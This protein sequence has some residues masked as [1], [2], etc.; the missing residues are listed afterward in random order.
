MARKPVKA[1]SRNTT[2][3]AGTAIVS[4]IA[5]THPEKELWPATAANPA[6]TKLDLARYYEAVAP[7]MLLHIAGRPLSMVRAPDGI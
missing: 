3:K 4:G 6:V 5:I 1:S 2:P 7:R